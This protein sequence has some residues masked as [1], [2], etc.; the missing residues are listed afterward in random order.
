MSVAK[1]L[2]KD[3][4]EDTDQELEVT[5]DTQES[6]KSEEK[7]PTLNTD[8]ILET[9]KRFLA[10]SKEELRRHTEDLRKDPDNE[11]QYQALIA[12]DHKYIQTMEDSINRLLGDRR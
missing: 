8:N 6:W 11:H 9:F 1:E 2:P 10:R 7:R 3:Q 4:P 12:Q 5:F